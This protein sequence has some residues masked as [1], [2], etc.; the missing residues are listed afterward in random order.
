VHRQHPFRVL[1]GVRGSLSR[2]QREGMMSVKILICY[3]Y[4]IFSSVIQCH[5]LLCYSMLYNGLFCYGRNVL[6]G[7]VL[8]FNVLL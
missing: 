6:I 4:G 3:C 7:A 5:A 2:K 1:G 8:L